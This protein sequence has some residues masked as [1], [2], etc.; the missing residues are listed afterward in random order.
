MTF[1]FEGP[2]ED[3]GIRSLGLIPSSIHCREL[4]YRAPFF[5]VLML[6]ELIEIVSML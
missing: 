2:T 6:N 5:Y 1:N 4:V 3:P